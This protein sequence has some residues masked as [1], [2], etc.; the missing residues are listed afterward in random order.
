MS[1]QTIE[2]RVSKLESE[3]SLL[4]DDRGESQASPGEKRGW[5]WFVGVFADSPDFDDVVRVGQEWRNAD[6]PAD[7]KNEGHKPQQEDEPR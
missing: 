6:R 2:E 1:Q 4:R 7:D 3:V 5:R